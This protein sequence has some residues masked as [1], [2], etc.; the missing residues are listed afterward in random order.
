MSFI[1]SAI[2]PHGVPDA[3]LDSP[4][5]PF[6]V[7][8]GVLARI[9]LWLTLQS[10]GTSISVVCILVLAWSIWFLCVDLAQIP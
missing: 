3:D 10:F 1:V 7:R 9:L 4:F 6:L 8:R 5:S 2:E